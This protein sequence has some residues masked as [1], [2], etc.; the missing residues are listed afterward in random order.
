MYIFYHTPFSI[1]MN[2]GDIWPLNTL[3]FYQHNKIVPQSCCEFGYQSLKW[4][5]LPF[6]RGCILNYD[7]HGSS[8]LQGP[9]NVHKDGL[10]VG[11]MNMHLSSNFPLVPIAPSLLYQNS[12]FRHAISLFWITGIVSLHC[13]YIASHGGQKIIFFSLLL[14]NNALTWVYE[15]GQGVHAT[16]QG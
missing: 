12:Q 7:L 4:I 9:A 5:R 1:E 15:G 14:L 11:R 2:I 6:L 16:P 8:I 3:P 13:K 10:S